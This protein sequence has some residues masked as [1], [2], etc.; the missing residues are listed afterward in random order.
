MRLVVGRT[1][2]IGRR[3]FGRSLLGLGAAGLAA[4]ALAAQ[5]ETG[6]GG[7]EPY[8]LKLP[9]RIPLWPEGR[10]EPA[11][12]GLVEHNSGG[13]V[14]IAQPRLEVFF[15][16]SGVDKGR[17]VLVIPGGGYSRLAINNEGYATARLLT[18]RGYTVCV[19]VY[20][21]P[22][23]GWTN[24]AQAPMQD[25]QRAIRIVR[26]RALDWS[27]DPVNVGVIGYSAGG[28]LAGMLA[29]RFAQPSYPLRDSIDSHPARP[30]YAA[31]IYPVI[32]LNE[33]SSH[34]VSKR[35]LLGEIPTSWQVAAYSVDKGVT[36]ETPPVFLACAADDPIVPAANSIAMFQAMQAVRG[37]AELH[38]FEAGGHGFGTASKTTAA[39]W[40]ELWLR[41]M[42][43]GG[44]VL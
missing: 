18:P 37:K 21:L 26:A 35:N 13:L 19:L 22:G 41:W 33:T 8:A 17:A 40:P 23:E 20:R 44:F 6:G 7:S 3:V 43:L 31:L 14:A 30:A 29:T 36:A 10:I 34:M 15:P 27:V 9:E 25:V 38:I 16:P 12:R 42:R 24:R 2:N 5:P 11:P 32:S 39:A 4:P 28:H 1:V